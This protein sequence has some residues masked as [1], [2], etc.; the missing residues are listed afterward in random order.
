MKFYL[1]HEKEKFTMKKILALALATV[2]AL[3]VLAGCGPKDAANGSASGSVS[4]SAAK[5]ADLTAVYTE[6]EKKMIEKLGGE[7]NAPVLVP[8]EDEMLDMNYPGLSELG[9]KQSVIMAPMMSAVA[10][11]FALVE[12]N[13]ADQAAKAAELF[14]ARIDAQVEGGAWYPET[15][16]SWEKDS[17][18]VTAGNYVMLVVM[19][20]NADY[21]EIFEN[22]CK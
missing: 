22:S 18:I 7:D 5:E 14:Q 19:E 2:M 8:M 4:G 11:E 13:D 3:G 6:I 10:V 12:A 21:I 16:E 1:L 15:I 9:L 17:K 20:D